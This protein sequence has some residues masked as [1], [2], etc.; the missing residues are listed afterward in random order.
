MQWN[1]LIFIWWSLVI[2][3]EYLSLKE[4]ALRNQCVDLLSLLN[5]FTHDWFIFFKASSPFGYE[6]IKLMQ[7]AQTHTHAALNSSLLVRLRRAESIYDLTVDTQ[8][9]KNN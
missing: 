5:L 3:A 4:K 6:T 8:N 7:T 9:S 1:I 2:L